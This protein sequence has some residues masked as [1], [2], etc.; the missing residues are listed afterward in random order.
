MWN[1]GDVVAGLGGQGVLRLTREG[2]VTLE[3]RGDPAS[4]REVGELVTRA[5][6]DAEQRRRQIAAGGQIGYWIVLWLPGEG[7]GFLS[8]HVNLPSPGIQHFGD[9]QALGAAIGQKIGRPASVFS[10][11]PMEAPPRIEIAHSMPTTPTVVGA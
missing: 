10:F 9:V 11:Q 3:L 5:Q 2:G 8:S 1:V 6:E 7:G 4:C